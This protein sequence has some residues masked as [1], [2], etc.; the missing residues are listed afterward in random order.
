MIMAAFMAKVMLNDVPHMLDLG[1]D[2][3]TWLDSAWSRLCD[4]AKAAGISLQT[5][6]QREPIPPLKLVL[7]GYFLIATEAATDEVVDDVANTILHLVD[8]ALRRRIGEEN[9]S[10]ATKRLLA[11]GEPILAGEVSSL[12]N[13]RKTLSTAVARA[14]KVIAI[15]SVVSM[16]HERGRTILILFDIHDWTP[17]A[18]SIMKILDLLATLPGVPEHETISE[19]DITKIIEDGLKSMAARANIPIP[20]WRFVTVPWMSYSPSDKTI[21]IP[22]EYLKVRDPRILMP[23]SYNLAHE[24]AHYMFNVKG[25]TFKDRKQEE[26]AAH[27]FAN[28]VTVLSRTDM[29]LVLREIAPRLYYM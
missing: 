21:Y 23:L 1:A 15:D 12:D 24:F 20:K 4:L 14:D 29:Q 6:Y 10:S 28:E 19:Y 8:A 3:P 9:T 13:M 26:D 2:Y 11:E 5:N 25:I 27:E 17:L 22:D 18:N 16:M 7:S